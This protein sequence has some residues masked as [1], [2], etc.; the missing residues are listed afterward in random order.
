MG[1]HVR[2]AKKAKAREVRV[3]KRMQGERTKK[4]LLGKRDEYPKF[5]IGSRNAHPEFIAAVEDAISSVDF[6]DTRKYSKEFQKYLRAIRLFGAYTAVDLVTET[7]SIDID[8]KRVSR[9]AK[10]V[11]AIIAIGR[12]VL[13]LVPEEIRRRHMPFN[14]VEIAPSGNGIAVN[15]HS[16]AS[17]RVESGTIF[18][19]RRRP[20][21]EF[22]GK[23]Y[24]VAFSKHAI[25]DS[26]TTRLRPDFIEYG[27]AGEIFAFFSTC[28]YFEPVYLH[29]QQ[30][31]FALFDMCGT[32]GTS[33]YETYARKVFGEQNI[34][35][36]AG[37]LYYRL[38]YCPV[39]L[40]GP[41]AKAKTFIPPGYC[42]TPEY[43]LIKRKSV[44]A[45]QR[46]RLLEIST[47]DGRN[48]EDHLVRYDAEA[49]KWFHENG[50]S[51]VF[52]WNHTVFKSMNPNKTNR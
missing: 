45:E 46:R 24:T 37:G 7:P 33:Q 1:K 42:K 4:L 30:P 26:L 40:E 39:V 27:S 2:Q 5:V 43:G 48:E 25:A 21:V 31:A 35:P 8:G 13:N 51:Q 22:D 20:T 38:G 9:Y 15:F 29:G 12:S 36:G 6:L 23:A 41:F 16:L 18:F 19:N 17:I 32:E 52:Q 44:S 10:Q 14:D 49:A 34:E 47:L 3:S 50:V 28:V 11:L